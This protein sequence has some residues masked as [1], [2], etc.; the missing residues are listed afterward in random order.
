MNLLH[1]NDRPGEHA[2]SWYAA[3]ADAPGPY[4]ELRGT[5]R[6][7]VAVVGGGFTGLSA[8]LALA[9]RGVS[10]ALI[11]AQRVGFGASGRNGGQ[12]G[13]G[14]RVSQPELERRHGADAARA[15]WELGAAAVDKVRA[16]V[17]E[18]APDANWRDGVAEVVRKDGFDAVRREAEHMEQV[19]G[20]TL[21]V[22]DREALAALIGS[23]RYAAGALDRV[24]GHVHPLRLAFGMARSA[25]AAGAR[26]FERSEAHRVVEGLVQ[27]GRGRIECET[28]I[29]ACNGYLGGLDGAVAAR[30]MP[31]NNFVVATEPLGERM[32]LAEPI[33]VADDDFVVNYWRPSED[34][35]LLF[36]GGESYGYRFPRDIAAVVRPKLEAV[37]PQLRGVHI[38]HAWGGTLAI[39][40]SR[41][42]YFVRRGGVLSASGYSGHGVALACLAGEILA[43]AARG[44]TRRFDA[45]ASLPAKAFPGGGAMRT[46][47]LAMA[48]TWYA[49]RDRL[50]L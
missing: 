38:D 1:A 4:P 33:A 47:L 23:E 31:I 49:A 48:M 24:A 26:L 27:T 15:L 46:P 14:Q 29:L 43:E 21:E 42:P 50:G 6:A 10:V 30:V 9:E 28:V 45:F 39:T 19:Y 36:G 35:R 34:G 12:V 25:E 41:M 20:H 11:D 16:L 13:M 7:D 40:R 17:R 44:E 37:Y 2:P 18:H 32:P 22:L 5:V 8:A 3:T